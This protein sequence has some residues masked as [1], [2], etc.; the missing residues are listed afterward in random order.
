MEPVQPAGC[1]IDEGPGKLARCKGEVPRPSERERE[2]GRGE[3][4]EERKRLP[5]ELHDE[6]TNSSSLLYTTTNVA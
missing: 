5:A 6:R 1:D 2:R 3:R 4:E